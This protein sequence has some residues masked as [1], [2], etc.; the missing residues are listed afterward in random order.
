LN[1]ST[2]QSK[3]YG[4]YRSG[5]EKKFAELTPRGMFKFEPYT[6]PYTIHRNYKPDF[7]FGDY[8]IECKGYF[9]VGDTQKYTAIRDSLAGQ[10]LIFVLSDPNKK[11]RK[12]AKMTMGQWC[13]KEELQFFTLQTIDDLLKYVKDF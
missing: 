1:R 10:E 4:I 7:V 6:I 3:S 8:L 11:L 2:K 12:G 13:E 9:R 5:L